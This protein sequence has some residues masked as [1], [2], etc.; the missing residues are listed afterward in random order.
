MDDIN[1]NSDEYNLQLSLLM[2]FS[3]NYY[4]PARKIII[5]QELNSF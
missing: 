3:T 1:N 5:N 4:E 2:S